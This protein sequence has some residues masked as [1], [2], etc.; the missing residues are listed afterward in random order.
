MNNFTFYM[1]VLRE[2]ITMLKPINISIPSHGHHVLVFRVN[3]YVLNG[4]L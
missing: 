3:N 2:V 1:H 4:H